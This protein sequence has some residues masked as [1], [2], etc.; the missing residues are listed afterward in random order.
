ME[1]NCFCCQFSLNTA[2]II[3]GVYEI[4]QYT[5]LF[6]FALHFFKDDSDVLTFGTCLCALIIASALL[7]YGSFKNIRRY[8]VS[9]IVVVVMIV[10]IQL[11]ILF[12]VIPVVSKKSTGTSDKSY[13]YTGLELFLLEGIYAFFD[14]DSKKN[15]GICKQEDCKASITIGPFCSGPGPE[16]TKFDTSDLSRNHIR[17]DLMFSC[18]QSQ[19]LIKLSHRMKS[20]LKTFFIISTLIYAVAKLLQFSVYLETIVNVIQDEDCSSCI[21]EY[22]EMAFIISIFVPLG[23]LVYGVIKLK[24]SYVGI[25]LV[26][27]II[28]LCYH[29]FI[30][31]MIR[32]EGNSHEYSKETIISKTIELLSHRESEVK[33]NKTKIMLYKNICGINLNLI[34]SALVIGC[35]DIFAIIMLIIVEVE[36][37]SQILRIVLGTLFLIQIFAYNVFENISYRFLYTLLEVFD[38]V[39]LISSFFLVLSLYN[40]LKHRD[41]NDFTRLQ[42]EV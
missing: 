36:Y 12:D 1:A 32:F 8:V 9:W 13:L 16:Q 7:V 25:W 2:G 33:S 30:Q 42:N 3:I 37:F 24:Q 27:H 5:L 17:F 35:Y 41:Q 28:L 15:K 19:F 18:F 20:K 34:K 10:L 39:V 38:Y 31:Y 14:Y 4:V 6:F 29:C 40:Q 23:F 21:T 26:V 11:M 22:F